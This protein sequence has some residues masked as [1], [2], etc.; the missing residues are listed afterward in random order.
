MVATSELI[1]LTGLTG[2]PVVASSVGAMLALELAAV[3]PEAFSLLVL[4]APLVWPIPDHGLDTRIHRVTCPV[5]LVWGEA[6]RLAPP[7]YLDFFAASLPNVSGTSVIAGA[8][9]MAEWDRP[10]EVAAIATRS[11]EQTGS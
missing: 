3:R 10:D 7:P 1:D 6:D 4:V 11:I 9:H 5:H 2:R 8:G